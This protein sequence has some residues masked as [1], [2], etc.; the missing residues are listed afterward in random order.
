MAGSGL[1]FAALLRS[2]TCEGGV[3]VRVDSLLTAAVREAL[4]DPGLRARFAAAGA[5][6]GGLDAEGFASFAGAAATGDLAA[7]THG[8]A[9]LFQAAAWGWRRLPVPV[10]AVLRGHSGP[11]YGVAVALKGGKVATASHDRTA[12]IWDVRSG[13]PLLVLSG[14]SRYIAASAL[15]IS[16]WRVCPSP[17]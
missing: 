17:G 15:I 14:H 6:P 12:R 5:V 16:S 13:Q 8:E 9:N 3:D 2:L 7:R 10:I 1:R 4:A 11:I